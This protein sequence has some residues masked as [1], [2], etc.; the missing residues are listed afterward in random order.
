NCEHGVSSRPCG[1]CSA[2]T[3][4]DEGRFVDMLEVD[5]ASRTKVEDTRELLEN[6]QYLPSAG[7]YKVYLIDEVHMLSNHS[8][9]ALLKTL[10]EPPPHVKFLL[11]TTDPQKLPVTILSRC[12]RFN[13]KA[14]PAAAITQHLQAILNAESIAGDLAALKLL[15]RAAEGSM[16]D[17]LSLL[18]QAIAFGGGQVGIDAVG[19]MLGTLDRTQVLEILEALAARQGGKVLAVVQHLVEMGVECGM[20]LTELVGALHQIAVAQVVPEAAAP[21][22]DARWQALAAN[23]SPEDVQ[24]YYQIGVLGRRDLPHAPDARSALEM[25]LLRMLAFQPVSNEWAPSV[26]VATTPSSA[27]VTR[28]HSPGPRSA[29]PA[30]VAKQAAPLAS[31]APPLEMLP[32]AD[33]FKPVYAVT[34]GEEPEWMDLITALNV[35]G[36]VRELARQC[37]WR[38]RE[39]TRIQLAIKP[40]Q[41]NVATANTVE[42][43][44]KA[45]AAY[46]NSPIKLVIETLDDGAETPAQCEERERRARQQQAEEIIRAD[47][48]VRAMQEMLGARIESVRP[49]GSKEEKK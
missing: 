9:N 37:T 22:N 42:R 12:L 15:A 10:E 20:V 7:R 3:A 47:P 16:R 46:Y 35:S 27:P 40:G 34:A 30:S 33:A 49:V 31:V 36:M 5:A 21:E 26:Q 39:G 38:G 1:K 29:P 24:L 6:V 2:C 13:L 48:N 18:D 11:A 32:I 8:F 19:N 17:A 28:P 14:I 4:I 41:A 25:T 45:L 43:L 44:Q 23:L